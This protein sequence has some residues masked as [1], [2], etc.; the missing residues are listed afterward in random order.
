MRYSKDRRRLRNIYTS[1]VKKAV[2]NIYKVS[3][4]NYP[5]VNQD[6]IILGVKKDPTMLA[7]IHFLHNTDIARVEIY[8]KDGKY[9][10][11]R[12]YH[13]LAISDPDFFEKF[14]EL[15]IIYKCYHYYDDTVLQ[16]SSERKRNQERVRIIL[17]RANDARR[18]S[19]T[20]IK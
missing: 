8:W 14:K 2:G 5:D 17:E 19:Q 15:F 13:D 16:I 20:N 7:A 4:S 10:G 11:P 9:C 18:R 3:L 12:E 1:I 6:T